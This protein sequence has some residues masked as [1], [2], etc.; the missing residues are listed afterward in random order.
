MKNNFGSS[1]GHAKTSE[2]LIADVKEAMNKTLKKQMNFSVEM[3][4]QLIGAPS[5][6][7]TSAFGNDLID[8]KFY[9]SNLNLFKKNLEMY[10]DLT[11]GMT[12]LFT[13]SF[14]KEK[15]MTNYSD[16]IF[17]N[18]TESYERQILKIQDFNNYFFE[19]LEKNMGG[20]SMDSSHTLEIV[21][22]NIK[23]NL[24]TSLETFQS[25]LKP[26]NKKMW[27]EI[28][29][30][31][32]SM[33]KLNLTLWS[34]L[35]LSMN[36]LM[37][38][39]VEESNDGARGETNDSV[40]RNAQDITDREAREETRKDVQEKMRTDTQEK[41]RRDAQERARKTAHNKA[42]KETKNKHLATNQ[43]K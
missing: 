35:I 4:N 26:N 39:K 22:E 6:N 29:T 23:E 15:E 11:K 30:Q 21:R 5:I 2:T 24:D 28:N 10:S 17:E 33:L 36:K 38:N 3:Y 42:G 7:E 43:K 19:T 9:K 16:K 14:Y 1:N 8:A 32:D 12:S 27:E 31:I 18:L 40:W 41:T 20:T 13:D 34:D 25:M 37:K